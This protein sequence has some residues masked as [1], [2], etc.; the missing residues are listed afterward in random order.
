MKRIFA[1][2]ATQL[3]A[4][5]SYVPYVTKSRSVISDSSRRADP[6]AR[7]SFEGV[8]N[9]LTN[10]TLCHFRKPASFPNRPR[11][12]MKCWEQVAA[13]Q[14]EAGEVA[15]PLI[16]QTGTQTLKDRCEEASEAFEKWITEPEVIANLIR[17]AQFQFSS[18][19]LMRFFWGDTT[20]NN[21][22][23]ELQAALDLVQSGN[24]SLWSQF[25]IE[26]KAHLLFIDSTSRQ[27]LTN[28]KW[29]PNEFTAAY[30]YWNF[31]KGFTFSAS[32]REDRFYVFHWLRERALRASSVV[33]QLRP[34]SVQGMVPWGMYLFD[35]AASEHFHFDSESFSTA[36]IALRQYT[37]ADFWKVNTEHELKA[38]LEQ[39]LFQSLPKVLGDRDWYRISSN[40]TGIL[41]NGIARYTNHAEIGWALQTFLSLGSEVLEYNSAKSSFNRAFANAVKSLR[42][43][44]S[45]SLLLR[46]H[47]EAFER[48]LIA[49][50][51]RRTE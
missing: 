50:N 14:H 25:E 40:A 8:V 49:A 24:S 18:D 37:Q 12:I 33:D 15:Y 48:A 44:R 46:A 30:I 41:L 45:V 29:T 51:V 23:S 19:E 2:D 16:Q 3:I 1:V 17:W 27:Q 31:V 42:F 4:A 6:G 20:P 13:K 28:R 10:D 35:I 22:E 43:R 7:E 5:D 9:I 26:F 38:F 36:I 11:P 34:E 39:G 32:L 47:P 21:T